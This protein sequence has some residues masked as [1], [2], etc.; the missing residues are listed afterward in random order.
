[1]GNIGMEWESQ[2]QRQ[3]S[4]RVLSVAVQ[5]QKGL[6]ELAGPAAAG[7][8]VL[9]CADGLRNPVDDSRKSA[10]PG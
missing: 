4:C 7:W 5:I 9:V 6:G 2:G 1:M 8:L 3:A 10:A